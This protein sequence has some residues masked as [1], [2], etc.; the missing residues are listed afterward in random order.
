MF[1][2]F[3]PK[4]MKINYITNIKRKNSKTGIYYKDEPENQ[5]DN[6]AIAIYTKNAK[7][8]EIK[9]GYVQKKIYLRREKGQN[10]YDYIMDDFKIKAL[11]T[12]INQGL[13]CFYWDKDEECGWLIKK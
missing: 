6:E 1:K 8:K 9:L 11:K 12:Q 2:I 3:T 7:D 4:E 13:M 5:Y 10:V